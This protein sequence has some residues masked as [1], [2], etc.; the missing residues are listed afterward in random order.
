MSTITKE[1][2]QKIADWL[3]TH[4][5]STGLGTKE[6]ACSIAAIDLSLTGKLTDRIPVGMSEVIR[7][8]II[9]TQDVL[10]VEI[11]NG[12][13]WKSLLPFA[14]GTGRAHEKERLRLVLNW[15]WSDVPPE[16][17]ELANKRGSESEWAKM[18]VNR[19][20]ASA[21]KACASAAYASA[22]RFAFWQKTDP[23]ALLAKLIAVSEVA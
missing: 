14:A 15:M 10:P 13:E 7:R 12:T 19:D 16:L 21:Q 8:W 1:R 5:A 17:Q 6:A 2:E 3:A 18:L 20:R 11:R 9:C 23:C 4:E 22:A